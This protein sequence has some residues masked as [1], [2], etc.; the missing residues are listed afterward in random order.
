MSSPFPGMDPYLER[1]ATWSSFHSKFAVMLANAIEANLA[2]QYYVEVET[3]TY[4]DDDSDGVMIGIPDATI[5]TDGLSQPESNQVGI[6]TQIRP[7]Q[8]IIP[9]PVTVKERYL[10][11][12]DVDNNKVITAIEILSPKNKAAGTGRISYEMSYEKKRQNILNSN[13]HLVEIDLLRAGKQMSI[14]G[15]A[16]D[17]AYRI[18]VSRSSQRPRAELYGVALWQ[19]LPDLPIPLQTEDEAVTVSLQSVLDALYQKGRYASRIDYSKA[20]PPPK[21]SEEEQ[22]WLTAY[23]NKAE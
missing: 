16:N 17:S 21:L 22:Q 1:P 13:T 15:T 6:V 4:Q 11:V 9:M 18:L 8:V 5:T 10:E 19:K 2:S 12:R 7:Q 14:L 20:P 3:R 23:H